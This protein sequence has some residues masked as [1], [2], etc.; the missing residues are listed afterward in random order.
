MLLGCFLASCPAVH[1]S[2]LLC[3]T[4]RRGGAGRARLPQ[5]WLLPCLRLPPQDDLNAPLTRAPWPQFVGIC[6]GVSEEGVSDDEAMLI[7]EFMEVV[8]GGVG[9]EVGWG[10]VGGPHWCGHGWVGALGR[11]HWWYGKMRPGRHSMESTA[12]P[13][14]MA[15]LPL[16]WKPRQLD[17]CQQCGGRT[18][19]VKWR[20][21]IVRWRR[22]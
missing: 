15:A 10:G 5:W 2:S 18:L 13:V 6:M 14:P 9:W 22:L 20:Q 21:L 11:C 8:W 17:R 19:I 3:C 12:K 16:P 7:C 4:C 1:P